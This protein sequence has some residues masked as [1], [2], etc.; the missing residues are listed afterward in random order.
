M[1]C[2]ASK[3]VSL[4]QQQEETYTFAEVRKL[5]IWALER[6]FFFQLDNLGPQFSV[7]PLL[8]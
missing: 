1:L 4:F 5:L 2:Q 3:L 6:N 8:I 7:L